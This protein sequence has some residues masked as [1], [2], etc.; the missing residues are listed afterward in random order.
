MTGGSGGRPEDSALPVTGREQPALD[1][2]AT[3]ECTT[4]SDCTGGPFV[5][6]RASPA[7]AGDRRSRLG[8]VSGGML[9]ITSLA[10]RTANACARYEVQSSSWPFLTRPAAVVPFIPT[11]GNG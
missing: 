3:C 7:P 2:T 9:T 8:T 10:V 4:A 11:C 1:A 5:L 6:R